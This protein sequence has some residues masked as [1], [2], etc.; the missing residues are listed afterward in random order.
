MNTIEAIVIGAGNA[1]LTAAATLQ[2]S[3]RQTLLVERHNIPGGCGTSFVRGRF[4]FEVALHQLSGLGSPDKPWSLYRLLDD[5]KVTEKINFVYEDELYRFVVPDRLDISLPADRMGIE[6]VLA[7]AFPAEAKSIARYFSMIDKL[8]PEFLAVGTALKNGLAGSDITHQFPTFSA[9]GM[10]TLKSVLDEFFRDAGLKSVL[11]G[12]WTYMGQP[13]SKLSFLDYA[14]LYWM[15]LAQK[16]AHIEGGSQALSNALLSSFHSMGGQSLFGTSVDRIIVEG[17]Q[18]I[19]IKLANGDELT[20]PIIISNAAA[21]ITYGHLVRDEDIPKAVKSD[22]LSRRV[23]PSGFTI[24][25][26]LNCEPGDINV[27]SSSTFISANFDEDDQY[28]RTKTLQAPTTGL[29]TCYDFADPG[30][31]PPG[32]SHV[33]LMGLHYSTPWERLSPERYNDAKYAYAEKLMAL[34]APV[35]PKLS[36]HI[37]EA[38]VATPLT[39]MRYLNHPGGSIYGFDQDATDSPIFRR[40]NTDIGGLYHVGAWTTLGGFQTTLENGAKT[41]RRALRQCHT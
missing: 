24:H 35:F 5:L 29:L 27:T 10:R 34:A 16:P 1:G 28:N 21:P 14:G 13:P 11:A 40:P 41:A 23:G 20:A 26:G 39:H 25:M 31:A 36:C 17:S 2:K 8:L 30:F 22:F 32:A 7:D 33:S 37:E 12:Y 9:I 4:E 15:Y 18:A 6:A 19:G 38:D 3:G